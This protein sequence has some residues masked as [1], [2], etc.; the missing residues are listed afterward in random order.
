MHISEMQSKI[1]KKSFDF[2]IM[3]FE[4]A[5]VNSAYCYRNTGHR[6]LMR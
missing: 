4:I 2:E 3:A 5:A 1:Q 6:Q